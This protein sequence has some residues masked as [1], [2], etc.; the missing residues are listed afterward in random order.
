[1]SGVS[2]KEFMNEH[3]A[4]VLQHSMHKHIHNDEFICAK[5]EAVGYLRAIEKANILKDTLNLA[6]ELHLRGETIHTQILKDSL[7][8]WNK[9]K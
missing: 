1:M 9:A 5:C 4:K 2:G 3:H 7:D 6:H 8:K